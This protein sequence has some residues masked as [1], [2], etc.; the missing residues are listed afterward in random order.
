MSWMAT[1]TYADFGT[2]AIVGGVSAFA[3]AIVVFLGAR[4]RRA[5]LDGADNPRRTAFLNAVECSLWA[6]AS[7]AFAVF[8]L[9]LAGL[10]IMG[11]AY[12]ARC[13]LFL[14]VGSN[15]D[16]VDIFSLVISTAL[17]LAVF[18]VSMMF[19]I[20]ETIARLVSR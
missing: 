6:C 20:S 5:V 11:L 16:H 2:V 7:V 18:M 15:C 9:V 8:H 10:L 4:R 19:E 12:I 17:I 3:A 1:E 13:L 14:R